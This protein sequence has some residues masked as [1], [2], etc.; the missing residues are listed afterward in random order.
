MFAKGTAN[1]RKHTHT[2]IT[3][4]VL[5]SQKKRGILYCFFVLIQVMLKNNDYF[6][7]LQQKIASK[8]STFLTQ[9]L[10][11]LL[12]TY[13]WILDLPL[14]DIIVPHPFAGTKSLESTF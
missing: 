12:L 10:R 6:K 3:F 1:I 7:T 9:F 4:H 8:T 11:I 2:P 13:A 5:H 14:G